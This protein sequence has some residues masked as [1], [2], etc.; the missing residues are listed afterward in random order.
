MTTKIPVQEAAEK[1]VSHTIEITSNARNF[2]QK[3]RYTLVD[4]LIR[5]TM[6]I[7]DFIC[8]ANN[9]HTSNDRIKL[10]ENAISSCRKVKFY[11][12]FTYEK[13][14]PKCSTG[15][16]N[17]IVEDIEKQLGNWRTDTK[18]RTNN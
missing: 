12:K 16:W 13:L 3:Y 7:H 5:I 17:G 9:A 2:P 10:I 4:R 14:H 15:Y 6:D 18:K 11:I 8:D 1:L